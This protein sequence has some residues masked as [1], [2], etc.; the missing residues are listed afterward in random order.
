MAYLDKIIPVNSSENQ[1]HYIV[2]VRDNE[3][4]SDPRTSP[5]LRYNPST[6]TFTIEG[7]TYLNGNVYM[8]G[9]NTVINSSTM[10]IDDKSIEL[11]SITSQLI[12]ATG[13][14]GT[15]SGSGTTGSPWVVNITNMTTTSGLI[16]GVALTATNGTG[17]FGNG[18]IT[19]SA[20]LSSSSITISAVGTTA[21]TAGTV[22]NI[23]SAGAS[24]LTAHG[25]G[26]V[27]KGNTDKTLLW[28]SN[29]ESWVSSEHFEM[30]ANKNIIFNGATS[31]S[32]ILKSAAI[33]GST[34]LTLPSG[35]GT[36]AKTSDL[37]NRSHTMTSTS[38]H[39]SGNWKL[40][41]SNGSG[42]ILELA[43]GD[44]GKILKSNGTSSAPGW[45]VDKDTFITP[46]DAISS[47]SVFD[48]FGVYP[49][50]NSTNQ[51]LTI[52]YMGTLSVSGITVNTVGQRVIFKDEPVQQENGVYQLT[53]VGNAGNSYSHIFT[54]A[55][56]DPVKTGMPAITSGYVNGYVR[57]AAS[58]GGWKPIVTFDTD[59]FANGSQPGIVSGFSQLFEGNKYF[60]FANNNDRIG[61]Q[62]RIGGTSGYAVVLTSE[63]LSNNQTL[64]LPN[65]SGTIAITSDIHSRS[66][67]MT[68]TSDH[69]AGNWKL[70]HSNGAGQVIELGMGTS[71]QILQANGATS[72]PTWVNPY[73]HPTQTAITSDNSNGVV[74]QDI[75]VNTSGHVTSVATVD[76][77][78][79]Y[80]PKDADLTA[81]AGL[82]GTSGFLKKTAADTWSLDTSSHLANISNNT[83]TGMNTITTLGTIT[84]GTWSGSTVAT[85]KGGTGFS[86]YTIGDILYASGATALSKLAGVAAGS[87]LISGGV[88]TAPIWGKIGLTTHITG[89]LGV[90]NGGTGVATLTGMVKG[91]GTSAMTGVTS[92]SGYTAYWSDANTIA[93]EA[94]TAVT[95]GGTGIGSYTVGDMLYAS[96]ATTLSKLA[97]VAVGSVLI[98]GGTN[99]A[100]SWGKADLTSHVTNILPAT[101]GGTGF[102]GYAV[103]DIL[104]ASST[105]VLSKLASAA[106]GNVLLTNGAGTAP[107]WGKVTLNNHITGTLGV[108]NGGT[109]VTSLT[110]HGV[111]VG[112]GSGAITALGEASNGQLLIGSTGN[113]PVLATL[114]AGQGI[115]ITNGAGSI[116]ITQSESVVTKTTAYTLTVDDSV[117][118]CDAS[119]GAFTLTLPAAS[120]ANGV[121]YRIKKIDSSF[122]AITIDPNGT[123]LIEGQ[124]TA[125][126][127]F[128]SNAIDLV[129]NGTAW[130]AL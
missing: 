119:A 4:A 46:V 14:V 71:G 7:D 101:N 2:F 115:K 37:H 92:T 65:K 121:V 15:V 73:S 90:G 112:S 49:S 32:I 50:Y 83:W 20:I 51:T 23:T 16:V 129:C 108:G 80:Q 26:L 35:T 107:S 99:T 62:P 75:S 94:Q 5:S 48:A 44:N 76:L 82:A 36:L 43:L 64:T 78:L 17:S 70:F 12:S 58:I 69:T 128:P 34:E 61:I 24:N 106:S 6:K 68:S 79:R 110:D 123:E 53:Q 86:S 25:G 21:P 88:A 117:I 130:Y 127:P 124:A 45:T 114:T 113:D 33:A 27:L 89:T 22:T 122:N 57:V 67:A 96:G 97:G 118:L 59:S 10:N 11:G 54:R 102:N 1:N 39:T 8:N 74:I 60:Q 111:L 100:P 85:D 72:A 126:L 29:N 103:G 120:T 95:R 30:P 13:T 28:L 41:Y 105:T 109:G 38:D 91:N 77:D 66:H 19:V 104:Y 56:D 98:S 87:A 42:Q 84:T 40:F 93:G 63:A 18:V 52:V 116:T 3:V 55:D 125:S 81:I 47:K 9:N 31:G